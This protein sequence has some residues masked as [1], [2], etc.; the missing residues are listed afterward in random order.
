MNVLWHSVAPWAKTGY[1]IQT[2]LFAPRLR[3]ELGHNVAI[4]AYA[5]LD[6]S[7]LKLDGL[8]VLPKG[9]DRVGADMLRDHA[10]MWDADV[11]ITLTDVWVL[12]PDAVRGLPWAAWVPVDH[13]PVP[14]LVVRA[15]KESG[16]VPVAMSRYGE[17]KLKAQGLDPL[18]V[19]HGCHPAY[20]ESVDRASA[21][22]ELSLPQDAFIIGSVGMNQGLLSRKG[23]PQVIESF[24]RFRGRHSDAF[25]Y[26]HSDLYQVGGIDLRPLFD[27][28]ALPPDAYRVPDRYQYTLGFTEE[29]MRNV[30]H[31]I[32][33]LLLPSMGEGF[34]VPVIEAQACGTPV[35]VT[36]FSALPEL[37]IFG[38]LL[39]PGDRVYT[40]QGAYQV[41]PRTDAIVEKLEKVYSY[42]EALRRGEGRRARDEMM[43]V[44]HPDRITRDCW[45]AVLERVCESHA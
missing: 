10:A 11:V 35:I 31:A 41:L 12:P 27:L 23:L 28:V 9:N 6:V 5:G 17:Q 34:G 38:E 29:Y 7:P 36:D 33:V 16:A 40:A 18:Y 37:C 13:D 43:R 20:F 15:L 3:D 44:Y 2:G 21:R 30:Y 19:P 42:S 14:P 26:L 4:F 22:Q 39:P 8:L 1:G 45:P 32:D 24:A 25:L